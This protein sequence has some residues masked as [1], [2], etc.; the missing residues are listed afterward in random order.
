MQS[1][2]KSSSIGISAVCNL[3]A[4]RQQSSNNKLVMN[5]QLR[6]RP[7]MTI[8]VLNL[9]LYKPA[10]SLLLKKRGRRSQTAVFMGIAN[11]FI[12]Q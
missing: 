5:K 7:I 10:L 1:G 3:F 11:G 9:M 12:K 8:A 4:Q 2:S 6:A